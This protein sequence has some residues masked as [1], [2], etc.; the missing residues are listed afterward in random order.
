MLT[1]KEYTLEEYV[2]A[3]RDSDITLDKLFYK[4]VHSYDDVSSYVMM[5]DCILDEYLGD[6]I[7]D[8]TK[9]IT[10]DSSDIYEGYT[11]VRLTESEFSKYK[12]NPKA[13]SYYLY[14]TTELWFLI[15]RLNEMYSATEFNVNPIKLYN[16]NILSKISE[17][18]NREED[19][20]NINEDEVNEAV[21]AA[22]AK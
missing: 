4:A 11:L 2:S 15:L 12:F 21:L 8:V 20:I 14:G 13:L 18:I 17:I 19:R 6:L 5:E 9:N 3:Y 22:E 10:G 1:F 7:G 16:N